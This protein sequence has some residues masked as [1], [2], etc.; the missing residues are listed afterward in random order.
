ML[1][2]I[3][4]PFA[5]KIYETLSLLNY[6][7][8]TFTFLMIEFKSLSSKFASYESFTFAHTHHVI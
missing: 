4:I 7:D 6:Y 2:L 8:L 3:N 5:N 1:H